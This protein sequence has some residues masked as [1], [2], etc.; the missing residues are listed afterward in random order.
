MSKAH[1][2]EPLRWHWLYIPLVAFLVFAVGPSVLAPIFFVLS[3]LVDIPIVG[4]VQRAPDLISILVYPLLL[5][6]MFW[7]FL[8]LYGFARDA[9]IED[10]SS[11]KSL[12]LATIMSV[13][14]MSVPC[15]P[16]LVA[17]PGEM[18]LSGVGQ[19]TGF[20]AFSSSYFCHFPESWD[21]LLAAGSRGCCG[22]DPLRR[23]IDASGMARGASPVASRQ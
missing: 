15:S 4:P 8:W 12:R 1:H 9:L 17:V 14:A 23:S 2:D 16:F 19:G 11:E 10:P 7:P 18:M 21:G 22:P 3:L 6:L 20:V 5:G 13:I